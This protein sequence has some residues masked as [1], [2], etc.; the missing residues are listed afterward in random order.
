MTLTEFY[1]GDLADV[2]RIE[3][4]DGNTGFGKEV[5][6]KEEINL[7]LNDIKDTKFIPEENQEQRDGFNYSIS[8]YKNN[9]ET[10]QFGPTYV[11]GNYYYTEPDIHSIFEQLYESISTNTP[12]EA[13]EVLEKDGF[14]RNIRVFGTIEVDKNRLIY[15]FEGEHDPGI[16][17][18]VA[19]VEKTKY[20]SMWVVTEA[21][22]IGSPDKIAESGGIVDKFFTG[23]HHSSEKAE[24][25]WSIIEIPDREYYIWVEIYE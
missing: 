9:E 20:N 24:D 18:F 23:F 12:D 1:K 14:A 21:M 7:F 6:E 25:A 19:N 2:S 3:I 22:G 11:N 16:D 4:V 13:I 5:T 15:A 8:L 17:W 10:F